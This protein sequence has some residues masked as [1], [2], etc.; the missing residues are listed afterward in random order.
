MHTYVKYLIPILYKT[1]T[2]Q[3]LDQRAC[4]IIQMVILNITIPT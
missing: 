1:L 3:D 4:Q 2:I